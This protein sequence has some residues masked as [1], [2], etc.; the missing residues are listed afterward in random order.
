MEFGAEIS[1]KMLGGEAH[2]G[3]KDKVQPMK[4]I[5]VYLKNLNSKSVKEQVEDREARLDTRPKKRSRP[6]L[7]LNF[8]LPKYATCGGPSIRGGTGYCS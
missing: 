6:F 5:N 4:Q 1:R 2:V 7:M 3:R 8:V